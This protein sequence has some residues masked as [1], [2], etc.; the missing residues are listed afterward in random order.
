MYSGAAR[1]E[2]I[3]GLPPCMIGQGRDLETDREV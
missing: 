2:R 3:D 1:G